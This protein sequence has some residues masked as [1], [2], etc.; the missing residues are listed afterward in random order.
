MVI[1]IHFALPVQVMICSIAV[2]IDIRNVIDMIDQLPYPYTL[3]DD[4]NAYGVCWEMGANDRR[5]RCT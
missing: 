1:S 4:F 5:V 3:L 2:R